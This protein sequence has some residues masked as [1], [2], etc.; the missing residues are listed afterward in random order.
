MNKLIKAITAG[1]AK[2]KQA[3]IQAT[4]DATAH[5][6]AVHAAASMPLRVAMVKGV[7]DAVVAKTYEDATALTEFLAAAQKLSDHYGPAVIPAF[8]TGLATI[9]E[10]QAA[11]QDSPEFVA[12]NESLSVLLTDVNEQPAPARPFGVVAADGSIAH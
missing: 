10:A 9:L 6:I 8:T 1:L 12:M 5:A 4:V 3:R 11:M 7:L 2:Y